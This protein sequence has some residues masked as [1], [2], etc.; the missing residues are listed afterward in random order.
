M[1]HR[2]I[3]NS[4]SAKS[5][6]LWAITI[7]KGWHKPLCQS[8]IYNSFVHLKHG[9]PQVVQ[10]SILNWKIS[11][12][13][14]PRGTCLRTILTIRDM[15]DLAQHPEGFEPLDN[16][17][18]APALPQPYQRTTNTWESGVLKMFLTKG[19]E[20][21]FLRLDCILDE[22]LDWKLARKEFNNKHWR[23]KMLCDDFEES[24]SNTILLSKQYQSLIITLKFG[25][26]EWESTIWHCFEP[27][28]SCFREM[29]RLKLS[30]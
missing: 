27:L 23:Q 22:R 17:G 5:R 4:S 10:L 30:S 13:A 21:F 15:E 9:L 8:T 25:L 16:K 24:S 29:I 1:L 3:F 12:V 20:K 11:C 26:T 19:R 6:D 18:C 14:P 7:S 2:P 28:S